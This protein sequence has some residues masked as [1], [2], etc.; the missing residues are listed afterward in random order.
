M[1]SRST[2]QNDRRSARGPQ[3]KI[4]QVEGVGE[5]IR[6]AG[7]WEPTRKMAYPNL[8]MCVL[9]TGAIKAW[10][11]NQNHILGHGRLILLQPEETAGTEP[12]PADAD[13]RSTFV[14]FSHVATHET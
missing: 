10:Y 1:K 7:F 8:G 4:W 9:E 2:K 3:L 12:R 11:R 6:T 13:S 14:P 5:A